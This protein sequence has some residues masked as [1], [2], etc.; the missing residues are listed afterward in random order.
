MSLIDM[1]WVSAI[2]AAFV[3]LLIVTLTFVFQE[4]RTRI[5]LAG[6]LISMTFVAFV[7]LVTAAASQGGVPDWFKIARA[8][9]WTCVVIATAAYILF[10]LG[11]LNHEKRRDQI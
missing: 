7:A 1:I 2:G 4:G 10:Q 9:A 5:Y 6:V 3:G 8:L 11:I